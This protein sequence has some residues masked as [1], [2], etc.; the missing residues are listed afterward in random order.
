MDGKASGEKGK[1]TLGQ[2]SLR[3]KIL[4]LVNVISAVNG[5]NGNW[6]IGRPYFPTTLSRFC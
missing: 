6:N 2:L 1:I 3:G 5:W 4:S